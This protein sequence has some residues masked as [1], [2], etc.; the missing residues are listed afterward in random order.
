M[1]VTTSEK[2]DIHRNVML[3]EFMLEPQF[4]IGNVFRCMAIFAFLFFAI[5]F[6][7]VLTIG[8]T[9]TMHYFSTTTRTEA[10]GMVTSEKFIRQTLVR[11]FANGFFLLIGWTMVAIVVKKKLFL[12]ADESLRKSKMIKRS[13]KSTTNLVEDY[14]IT[15]MSIEAGFCK[16]L[17]KMS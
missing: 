10:T 1:A 14:C 6:K 5:V 16:L 4:V 3:F 17:A 11:T 12:I 13:A 2:S 9:D 15:E 7:T 8:L